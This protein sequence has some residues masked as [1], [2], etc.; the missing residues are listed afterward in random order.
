M[1]VELVDPAPAPAP[2]HPPTR[3]LASS[4]HSPA[5]GRR[6]ARWPREHAGG[7]PPAS[8]TSHVSA[9]ISHGHGQKPSQ[10][11]QPEATGM[12]VGGQRLNPVKMPILRA[13]IEPLR[14]NEGHRASRTDQTSPLTCRPPVSRAGPGH[15]ASTYPCVCQPLMSIICLSIDRL[16]ICVC[17]Y[18]SISV[19]LSMGLSIDLPIYLPMHMHP[20]LIGQS[21]C[22][23]LHLPTC[24]PI[25]PLYAIYHSLPCLSNT[26]V[27]TQTVVFSKN[28]SGCAGYVVLKIVRDSP[29]LHNTSLQSL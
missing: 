27:V 21:T 29:Q 17:V 28:P 23:A 6:V 8:P 3:H 11:P 13:A 5:Q 25:Y 4:L 2:C 22:P 9:G 16:S 18:Q 24:L 15:P 1:I 10:T 20:S 12:S 14:R 26:V 19:C 7:E